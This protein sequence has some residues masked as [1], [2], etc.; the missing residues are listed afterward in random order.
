MVFDFLHENFLL[1]KISYILAPSKGYAGNILN[2]N[3]PKLIPIL[4]Q[5]E[6]ILN[7]LSIKKIIYIN[8]LNKG[9][10]KYIIHFLL[11]SNSSIFFNFIFAPVKLTSKSDKDAP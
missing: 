11:L 4:S 8:K 7:L 9:P 5:K 2:I 3:S 6:I 1:N 10:E